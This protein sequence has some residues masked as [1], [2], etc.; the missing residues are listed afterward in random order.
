MERIQSINQTRVR[1]CCEERGVTP[2]EIADAVNIP[3][4]TFDRMM[5]GENILTFHQLQHV[6]QFFNRGVLFFLEEGPVNEDQI[7]S[8][9]FRTITNQSPS[10]DAKTK[11]LIE[12]VEQQRAVYVGLREDMG[13]TNQGLFTPPAL[14]NNNPKTVAEI[15]RDWLK[16]SGQASFESYRQAVESCGILVFRTNGYNGEWQI[17]KEN[18]VIGFSLFDRDCPVIVVKKQTYESR[19][20]FTLMH[21]LGHILMHHSS[22]VDQEDDLES[23]KGNEHEANAFAGYLLVPDSFLA[24]IDDRQKPTDAARYDEWLKAFRKLLG[25]STEVILRRLLDAHRLSSS[26]YTAYRQW[27]SQR[28]ISHTEG[29]TRMYRYRE[30]KHIFGEPYVRIVLDALSA[31]QISLAKASTYLDNLKIKDLHQLEHHIAGL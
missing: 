18:P 8:I 21:E 30:P 7:H 28:P 17:D 23:G 25:V 2:K 13:E 26:E 10:L 27:I 9:Q 19:Q 31:K 24:T 3:E 29:G 5:A 11:A 14:P 4:A 22:F 1:W 12:R 6:A 16:I 20:T 15:A